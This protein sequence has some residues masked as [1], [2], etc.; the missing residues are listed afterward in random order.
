MN[1][2]DRRKFLM[3]V[4]AGASALTLARFVG[5]EEAKPDLDPNDAYAMAM[6]F[7]TDTANADAEKFPKHS[8]DQSCANCQLFQGPDG[9]EKGPCSFFGGRQVPATGWCRNFKP[10]NAA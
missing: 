6:G 9:A 5:A 4:A 1:P 7:V 8:A 2:I 10:K 3:Q